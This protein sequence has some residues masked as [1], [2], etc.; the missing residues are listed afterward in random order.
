MV[1]SK[2]LDG[3]GGAG[4]EQPKSNAGREA[5]TSSRA[6]SSSAS[7]LY[8]TT[9]PPSSLPSPLWRSVHWK[10]HRKQPSRGFSGLAHCGGGTRA[11]APP[12]ACYWPTAAR[13]GGG[14]ASSGVTSSRTLLLGSGLQR[15]GSHR[16]WRKD[17]GAQPGPTPSSQFP[18]AMA[19][20]LTSALRTFLI[21]LVLL[22]A[23]SP[24]S[25]SEVSVR[26]SAWLVLDLTLRAG[27][28]PSLGGGERIKAQASV[29]SFQLCPISHSPG[30]AIT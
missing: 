7:G 15:L 29:W 6:Q 19:C 9:V 16:L 21:D 20:V 28:S 1:F 17:D 10:R 8:P 5:P 18:Q 13:V 30:A 27:S 12:S 2:A 4:L 23:L 22:G 26:G 24:R 25:S 11:A 14:G 3:L